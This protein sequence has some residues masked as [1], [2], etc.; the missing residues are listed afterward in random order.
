[1]KT[2]L[3]ERDITRI[4]RQIIK[5]EKPDTK[6]NKKWVGM[7][8]TR[9][10][11]GNLNSALEM[12]ENLSDDIGGMSNVVKHLKN[13]KSEIDKAKDKLNSLSESDKSR[14]YKRVILE[15]EGDDNTPKSGNSGKKKG[16]NIF[17]EQCPQIRMICS[18]VN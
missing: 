7:I 8:N 17:L 16:M 6:F 15:E 1:M 11:N 13:A 4:V 3:T 18:M 5:E 14:I 9:L 10:K 2:R 12:A